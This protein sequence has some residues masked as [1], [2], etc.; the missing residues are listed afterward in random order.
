MKPERLVPLI[1]VRSVVRSIE[2]YARLGFG[3][4]HTFTPDGA[5]EPGW[6]SLRNGGAELMITRSETAAPSRRSILL[7]VYCEDVAQARASLEAAGVSCGPIRHPFYAPKGEF[8]VKDPDGY[9]LMITH[10]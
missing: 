3:A 8:E 6:A 7:Y 2:F 5:S 1:E 9:L 10:T 4:A